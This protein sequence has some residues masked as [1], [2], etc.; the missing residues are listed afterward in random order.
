MFV[1]LQPSPLRAIFVTGLILA[2]SLT[3]PSA[4][5]A[6]P[7]QK[8]SSA[9]KAEIVE[10]YGRL[11][12]SFEANTGQADKSVRFLSRGRGYGLYLTGNEAVLTLHKTV[13]GAA[14]PGLQQH[15]P[16]IQ[17][18]APSDVVRMQLAGASGK[19]EPRGEEP[20]PGTVN[21][22][23]GN[24]PAKWH[25]R[26]PT[27]AKVRYTG[28]YP[29]IDLVY[30]GNPSADGQLEYDFVVA[31]GADPGVIALEVAAGL[32]RRPSSKIGGVP[33]RSGQVPPP[34][35]SRH[36]HGALWNPQS[37]PQIQNSRFKSARPV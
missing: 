18:S 1:E 4:G 33:T 21:Y 5:P 9:Q 28:I 10:N 23:I 25:T 14:K 36:D 29:G 20:L 22:F 2:T 6:S 26:V 30:Y 17:K 31:P 19:A 34:L 27:Y 3:G 7:S 12:L 35:Q 15:L 37:Q 13:Y 8:T 11:P 24:D 16:P 32:S